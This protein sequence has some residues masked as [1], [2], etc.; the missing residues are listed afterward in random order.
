M[1]KEPIAT[2]AVRM[3][4][5]ASIVTR[6]TLFF[7]AVLLGTV[8]VI[9]WISWR[10]SRS[11][12]IS[13]AHHTMDHTLDVAVNRLQSVDRVLRDNLELLTNS[14][15]IAEW[16]AT[17]ATGDT[18]RISSAKEAVAAFL[19]PVMRSRARI[20]QMRLIGADPAGTEVVRFDRSGRET[21]RVPEA[22]LQSKA[23]RG[24]YKTTMAA[25][26]GARL[27][28]PIDLNQEHGTLERPFAPTWRFAAP[29]FTPT[30]SRA[31]IMVIN[32]DLRTLYDELLAMAD[33]GRVLM[34]ARG[35]GQVI[36]HPDTA[37]TFQFERGGSS[38]LADVFP[39]GA[40]D[41]D[42]GQILVGQRDFLLG[43]S[44]ERHTIV[45]TQPMSN[46]LGA[47][48][49]KR[50]GLLLLFSS[51]GI[52]A[53]VLIV[54]FAMGFR[55]RL[56]RLTGSMER[57]AV[58]SMEELPTHRQDEF[59]RMALGLRTMQERI[60][61][62][63]RELESARA[64][65]EASDRQRRDLLANMSHEVRTPLNAIIGMG[66]EV[67]ITHMSDTDRE[68]MAI[69][70]RSAGRLKGLVDDLLMHARIGE[71]KLALRLAPVD[72]RILV[73][74]VVHAHLI[75]ARAKGLGLSSSLEG[76]PPAMLTD[77]LR[78]HQIIDNLVGN[79]VRFTGSGHVGITADMQDPG[80]LRIHVQ[81]TGPGIP[82]SEQERVFERFERATASEQDQGAGLGLAITRRV[83]DLLGGTIGLQSAPGKG[84]RFTVLIPTTAIDPPQAA[85]LPAP[86]TS[87]L[88]VLYVEDVRTNRLL[89]QEWAARWGWELS[90]SENAEQAIAA[91]RERQYE[92]LLVDL[93][94]GQ[95]M[96]G[97]ELTGHL[98]ASGRNV[99]TPM[100][101]LTAHASDGEDAGL[102]MAG[103]NARVTKPVD[104]EELRQTIAFWTDRMP[105]FEEPDLRALA[106]Q[107]DD[108]GKI[109]R[110]VYQQYR[111]EFTTWRLALRNGMN[112]G[113]A[114]LL[115][116]VRHA[117]RPHW[118]LLGLLRSVAVLNGFGVN[119]DTTGSE[120]IEATFRTCDRAFL[121]AMRE[122][123][124]E[125][126]A[127]RVPGS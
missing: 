3:P 126:R 43:P 64:A 87:G 116:N 46:L 10:T 63:V 29:V 115:G 77:P 81:D 60:D 79:A 107:Y 80:T 104:R 106:A 36:M 37:L 114:G 98:R 102:L 92:V 99:H 57:Y 103:M 28:F 47:L 11:E 78:L 52:A 30:G 2:T 127:A 38:L 121:R 48:Q 62:R 71:G 23:A 90:V 85:A 75:T 21:Y 76:L 125:E 118:Q 70:Q 32:A 93:Q 113:D 119:G 120:D 8:A 4:W 13:Q 69:V 74:D 94:L 124:Q 41:A 100:I 95:G 33:S 6:I 65:A 54:L 82:S 96:G 51:I 109:L 17:L 34:M 42:G 18:A 50:R 56:N 58:G 24:Y 40:V 16:S 123:E 105:A 45:I 83:V 66:A 5:Y 26:A 39:E 84:T 67:D 97:I 14:P 31:G 7:S 53:I 61:A 19:D 101:A 110:K 22:N 59:G 20:S 1:T 25:P 86:D 111:I 35:D 15:A 108:D 91:C 122:L 89:L 44:N 117:V 88:R 72:V 55:S 27:A 112:G 12:F 49:A 73:D 9:G 68:R